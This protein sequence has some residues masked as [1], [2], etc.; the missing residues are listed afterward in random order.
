MS[1]PTAAPPSW[2]E[3]AAK[4]DALLGEKAPVPAAK[5]DVDEEELEAERAFNDADERDGE[6]RE[7]EAPAEPVRVS[8]PETSKGVAGSTAPFDNSGRATQTTRSRIT[9]PL[10]PIAKNGEELDVV[11]QGCSPLGLVP[12]TLALA[13]FTAVT[14]F[15]V[16][17][18]IPD[19]VAVEGP[20][21]AC[22]LLQ[23][24]RGAY[25]LMAYN[26]RVTTRRLFRER[27]RLY[28]P[29]PPL[30]L[31]TVVRVE[32]NQTRL[33]RWL[34]VGTVRVVPEDAAPH[35]PDVEIIGVA[36]PALLGKRLDA[37]AKAAREFGVRASRV[38][39]D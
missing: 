1:T 35:V 18:W 16:R 31:S 7:G 13:A 14:V 2:L 20:L 8:R 38:S 27:G 34:G 4:L 32:V 10:I 15:L 3:A 29:E 39:E 12:S 17:P 22:W 23:L 11:W 19:R 28:T 33:E 5:P 21:A 6:D 30:D 24:I 9:P 26:Y 37:A 36:G 25:R